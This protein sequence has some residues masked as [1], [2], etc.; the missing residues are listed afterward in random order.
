[1][2]RVD[3]RVLLEGLTSVVVP[4]GVRPR[5][6]ESNNREQVL[7]MVQLGHAA[8]PAQL[9]A[10]LP[11]STASTSLASGSFSDIFS[12][13]TALLLPAQLLG[14]LRS[15]VPL[16]RK[17]RAEQRLVALAS[18]PQVVAT[19]GFSCRRQKSEQLSRWT[20][21]GTGLQVAKQR[22]GRRVGVAHEGR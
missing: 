1:M 9:R 13:A 12:V 2:V 6:M 19:E 20:Q 21:H 17:V 15:S 11:P 5:L 22:G 7:A 18:P 14:F 3:S 4:V 8:E 10:K 16:Q